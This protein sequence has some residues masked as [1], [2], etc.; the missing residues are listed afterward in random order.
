[1]LPPW[2]RASLLDHA[3]S[4][5]DAQTLRELWHDP[6]AR[7]LVLDSSSRA[8]LPQLARRP[9]G[10]LDD[11]V[12]F[13][14]LVGKQPW[15]TKRGPVDDGVS[16]REGGLLDVDKQLITAAQAV[17]NWLEAVRLCERCGGRLSRTR[18]GFA[19]VCQSCS[20]EHF[21]RTDPAVIVAILNGRD[22]L[23]LAHK[24]AWEAHRASVLAG[25]VESGES[26]ENAV[27]REIGEEAGLKLAGMRYVGSQPW[28]FPRSLMLAFVARTVDDTPG[29]VDGVELEW[30][31]F[32]SREQVR[33]QAGSG[34]LVLPGTGSISRRLVDGWL[35]GTLPTPEQ[36]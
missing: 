11:D 16:P 29:H 24:V 10:V 14:G 20:H 3:A 8:V 17:L 33:R 7:L 9:H 5:R 23:F 26:A 32:F 25:F 35:T 30:G 12:A 6:Q 2:D 15:F 1:M 27:H 36:S 18:G 19:A 13:L 22:E 34:S 31:S 28:P 21:P 4:Q